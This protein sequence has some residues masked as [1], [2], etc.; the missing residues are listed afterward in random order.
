MSK[1]LVKSDYV[2]ETSWEVCNKVGGIYTVIST[3]A[4]SFKEVYGDKYI[5][6]GPDVWHDKTANKEFIEDKELYRAWHR[7]AETDGLNFRIGRWNIAGAPIVILVDFTSFFSQKDDMFS[8]FWRDYKLDSLSGQWDYIEPAVFGYA[9]GK[10]IEHF[11]KFNVY[12]GEKV[13]AQFHE[14]MTGTGILYLKSHVP[15]IVNAFTTHATALGRSIAGNGLPLYDALSSY[16]GET[17]ASQFQIRSKFSLEKLSAI[18]ADAF[19]TV[20]EIT[21]NECKQFFGKG[22]DIVTPN[23][24]DDS[25]VPATDEEFNQKRKAARVKLT[26]VAQALMNQKIDDDALFVINS[27]RYEFKNKGIDVFIDTLSELNKSDK[28]KKQVVAFLTIPA[29]SREMRWDVKNRYDNPDFAHPISDDYCT[30]FLNNPNA[31]PAI[32]RLR[33]VG[34]RNLPTDKVKVVFVPCYLNGNDGMID[35]PYYDVLIG[36][37]ASA[38]PSYYEPWGYTPMES[39]AFKIPTITTTLAG[40]GMWIKSSYKGKQPGVMVVERNDINDDEVV[41][42]MVNWLQNLTTLSAKQIEALRQNAYDVSRIVLWDKLADKYHEAYS[43]GIEKKVESGETFMNKVMPIQYAVIKEGAKNKPEWRKV[44]INPHVSNKLKKLQ[45]LSMN[46]WWSWNQEAIH[47]FES[48]HKDLWEEVGRNPVA[49]LG[50]L[51]APKMKEL[52]NDEHFQKRLS[53]IYDKFRAYMDEPKKEGQPKVAYFS[54]EYGLHETV[55]IYS[56]GLGMLAGDYLKEASDCNIDMLGVGL[57]YRYGYFQQHISF[58]G[59]QIAGYNPQ[60]FTQMPLHPVRDEN[61]Q[62][63]MV[64]ISLPGRLLHAKVW[65]LDVGRVPL[66]LLDTDIEENNDQDRSITY[67]LYGGDLENRF[68]QELL[69]GVG[70]VRFLHKMGIH[71]NLYHCNEGHGAFI[72]VERLRAYIEDKKRSYMAAK[73][74]VRSSTLF[75]THT[76]VPAGHDAFPEDLMRTY[77]SHYPKRLNISWE[78]FMGLGRVNEGDHNEKFSM[79]NLAIRL[80]QEVNGVSRI[81]GRVSR[82]MFAELFDGYFAEELHIGYVT[83]GVHFQTWTNEIWQNLYAKHFGKEFLKDMSNDEYW[84][85]IYNVDDREIHENRTQL[86][87]VMIDFVKERAEEDMTRREENP[88]LI[89]NTI[90]TLNPDVL[91]IGFAR[92]FATYKRA[93]LLFKNLDRLSKLVN[94]PKYPVQFVFAGKAHPADK[95]GQDLIKNIIEVSRRPEFAGKIVFLENYDFDIAKKL[96]QGVDIWL[97]TPTRPLEASGTSGEKAIMNGV[98]NL[99]V[100]DGWWAEGYKPG[101]G[102]ALKEE[103][104]YA[105]NAMQDALDAETV[106]NIIQTEIMPAFYDKNEQGYSPKWIQ[107]IKNNIAQI[108]P[109]F[110]MKR[111]LDDYIRQYYTPLFERTKMMTENHA[112][113][114]D[115]YALW[116]AHMVENWDTLEVIELRH[117]NSTIRPLMLGDTLEMEIVLNTKA[118]PSKYIGIETVVGQKRNDKV[119]HIVRKIELEFV[120]EKNGQSLYRAEVA[121]GRTGVFDFA[122][123]IYPKHPLL[124][125]RQD[126]DLVKWV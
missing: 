20:S 64:K 73:E 34:L 56:G 68:K 2:F 10:I 96:V 110:T 81:H 14:W 43:Q 90:E 126:F 95:A 101:A 80:S 112:A 66:Y 108:A 102:W 29:D 22:V 84:K 111:Q 4:P 91:T 25:F 48:I 6:I 38:F 5:L 39:V 32:K 107:Y 47:L 53:E 106:Y 99:S 79:S 31:D 15:Q 58:D 100:L 116:K 71:P 61:G 65:R 72:G 105:N 114:A 121:T 109:H 62:W 93:H 77:I 26:K 125:N 28:L 35:L 27:G 119:E 30:H 23:G 40:F 59:N 49:F 44:L 103:Q 21:N 113:K 70:G 46:L 60:R 45:E 1:E 104:T 54:M 78:A 24:F 50:A 18:H 11:H 76:P 17:M 120:E 86:R 117:T 123:R 16:D 37:D 74:L 75:T 19:T 8:D 88:D 85:K 36:M 122:Y 51:S 83:N 69:L 115:E 13:V 55:K 67:Q 42:Q 12:P 94:H 97:N 92:R 33:E 52:E 82:E 41:Q 57:L 89:M 118:I 3:K 87:K 124:P 98:L 9:A 63:V 7:Q